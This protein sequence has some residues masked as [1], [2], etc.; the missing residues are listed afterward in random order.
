MQLDHR[1]KMGSWGNTVVSGTMT[2]VV[3]F[4]CAAGCRRDTLPQKSPEPPAN[5]EAPAGDEVATGGSVGTSASSAATASAE[6]GTR[7]FRQHCAACHGANGNGQGIAAA[8]LY[9]KPRDFTAGKFRLVSTTNGIPSPHDL[10]AV[11]QRGMPGSA[12]PP[13]AHLKREEIEALVEEVRRLY[14]A[15]VREQYIGILKD[16]EGLTDE[17]ISA[18]DVQ[19]DIAAFVEARTNPGAATEVPAVD[20]PNAAAIAHGKEIYVKQG[21]NKCHGDTGRGDGQ[22]KMVDDKGYPTRP[23]DFTKG[24]FK[25]GHDVASIYRRIAYG[26]P[27]TQMPSSRDL[28]K[29]DEMV[30]LAHY[31]LS[32]SSE[33]QRQATLLKRQRIVAA[34]VETLP[35]DAADEAWSA[36]E[37]AGLRMI[38]LWWRDDSDPDLQVQAVHDGKSIAIRISW[39]DDL[40]DRHA[41]Q[42]E[43]FE[44]AVAMEVFRGETEP[45]IGMGDPKSPVDVWYWDAD[46]Q[47]VVDVEDQYPN[48]AVDIYPF[49]EKQAATAEFRREGTQLASQPEVSLPALAAGNQITPGHAATGGSNLSGGGP[50]SSTF[51]L[52]KSQLVSARGQWEDGRWSVIMTRS[53]AV[54]SER[55]GVPLEPGAK[56]SVAFAVWDG[57]KQDR[58]GKKLIT[59]WHDLELK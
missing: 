47:T 7:L 36:A 4:L 23:R 17:D 29:P 19:Q 6:L 50:G 38:P 45:F 54:E 48:V 34:A 59:I 44:D 21:C 11:L 46:R 58:D 1:A 39:R 35:K 31:V 43:S 53:L 42:S 28:L 41:A 56:A 37:P 5:Q 13:W 12:M 51:R 30:D 25:G 33:E 16:N 24:I 2:L 10:E 27:G 26:M 57:S 3:V 40:Q 55:D 9:P 52:P 32:L 15:G 22:Q 18:D 49:S 8:Y 14:Q 20:E